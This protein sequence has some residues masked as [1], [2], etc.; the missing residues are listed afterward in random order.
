MN[1][2]KARRRDVFG[3]TARKNF[4]AALL[5]ICSGLAQTALKF[6]AA[7]VRRAKG[8]EG[9]EFACR[10]V[11]VKWPPGIPAPPL[12]R[13]TISNAQLDHLIGL[14]YQLR[15]LDMIKGGPPWMRDDNFRFSIQAVAQ[16]PESATQ[17]QLLEMMKDLLA[18]RFKVKIRV[19]INPTQGYAL[20]VA[21][22]SAKIA[23]SKKEE[24]LE[25][26]KADGWPRRTDM[27]QCSMRVL[28]GILSN[29]F[30]EPVVDE[31][32][33]NGAFDFT[34]KL[35]S[36]E[37]GSYTAAIRTLGLRLERRKVPVPQITVES[38]Q[39]PEDN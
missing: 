4:A 18:D 9:I 30:H 28:A 15:E 25:V 17:D 31:T 20:V 38:A 21:P 5:L 32:G 39:L 6:E 34:L 37:A 1:A 22:G 7:S 12:G 35:E 16:H 19:D 13:C 36:N 23:S 10:G 33:L 29:Q 27:R 11:D 8:G 14:T 3:A 26:T 2:D 24:G